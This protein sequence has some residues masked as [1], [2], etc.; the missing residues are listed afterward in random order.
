[1]SASNVLEMKV[2]MFELLSQTHDADKIAHFYELLN[3]A[4]DE[5]TVDGWHDLIAE[6]QAELKTAIAECDDPSNLVP[7]EEAV[8][9]IEQWLKR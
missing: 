1:M 6:Q 4:A 5:D 2:E 3:D 8:K 7:Q 9:Q